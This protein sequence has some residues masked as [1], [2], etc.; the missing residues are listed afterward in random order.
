MYHFYIPILCVNFTLIINCRSVRCKGLGLPLRTRN[1]L[2][3]SSMQ[4]K[5]LRLFSLLTPPHISNSKSA[6]DICVSAWKYCNVVLRCSNKVTIKYTY[7]SVGV[8]CFSYEEISGKWN[9]S[10]TTH[11]SWPKCIEL[12]LWL[13]PYRRWD[14][15]TGVAFPICIL[16]ME[17]TPTRRQ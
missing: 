17:R 11:H 8:H 9:L 6:P 10:P 2:T 3:R 7:N 4:N 12:F 13:E 16:L 14:G 5:K 1:T 15:Q